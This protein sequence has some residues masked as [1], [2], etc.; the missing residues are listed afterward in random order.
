MKNPAGRGGCC[1]PRPKSEGPTWIKPLQD[2]Q[3][4]SHPT[5]SNL[6]F[7]QYTCI[8]FAQTCNPIRSHFTLY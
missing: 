4:S 6:L 1:P 8:F 3:N 5:K 7:I 2:L